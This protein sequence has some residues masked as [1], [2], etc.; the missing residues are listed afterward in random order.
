MTY[1]EK[2]IKKAQKD[3]MELSQE[4]NLSENT[5]VWIGN[6]KYIIIRNG[7]EIRI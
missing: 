1:A 4:Y 2:A 6:N 7:E 3:K 5:I